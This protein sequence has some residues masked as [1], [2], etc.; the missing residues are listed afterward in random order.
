MA[1]GAAILSSFTYVPILAQGTFSADQ[2]YISLI[3]AAYAAASFLASYIFGRA[4]D[5]FG[6]RIILYLGLLLSTVTFGLLIVSS[7]L[8]MLF[9]V[10]ILNGFSIGIYPGALAAYAYESTMPM[11]RFAS[12]GALGWGIGNILAGYAAGFNIYFA[13]VVAAMFF[14]MAFVSAIGLPRIQTKPIVV[15]LFPIETI[16]RNY[17]VY[18]AM[19]LRH[20]SA[21]ALWTYW[22]LFL[23][24]LGADLLMIGVIQ[25][26]NSVSQ[27]VF[28][29]G[30][31]DRFGCERLI[32][33][34]LV[35]TA[36]AF[37]WFAVVDDFWQIMP[38]QI[39]LGFSWACLYVGSLKYVTERNEE[40]AT[41]SG[42]LMS[43]MAIS[44]VLGPI[45]AAIYYAIWPSYTPIILNVVVMSL[46]SLVIFRYSAKRVNATVDASC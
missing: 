13:F 34:G 2:F 45:M 5:I 3:V 38:A 26:L 6:R 4:G 25:A 21:F 39:L 35:S 11:G 15:P 19:L 24:L 43:V 28:M 7:S 31:T 8:E 36:V 12:F 29:L 44:G 1:A 32:S 27:V 9:I 10:R 18:V 46:I 41:A 23:S 37:L 22:P 30:I 17:P 42:L 40:R 20:S 14:V 16:K 33:I